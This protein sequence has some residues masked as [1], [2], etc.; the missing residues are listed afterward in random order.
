MIELL[1]AAMLLHDP[2]IDRESRG[3]FIVDPDYHARATLTVEPSWRP[4]STILIGGLPRSW[5]GGGFWF[6]RSV[7]G[8]EGADPENSWATTRACPGSLEAL[9]AMRSVDAPQFEGLVRRESDSG[10]TIITKDGTGYSLDAP[11]QFA[12]GH[13]ADLWIRSN[14]GDASLA[15][16]AEAMLNALD[17]CW[18]GQPPEVPE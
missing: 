1:L 18:T 10:S 3:D 11:A 17:P 16:W 12:G 9:D 4:N 15:I 7:H 13:V 2:V 5:G 6:H 8:E 14:S